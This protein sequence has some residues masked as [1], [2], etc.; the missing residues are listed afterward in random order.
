MLKTRHLG[1]DEDAQMA[2]MVV[3]QVDDALAR[4]LQIPGGPVDDGYPAK[5]LMRRRDIVA[6]GGENDE[7]ILYTPQ[8]DG[9]AVADQCA[10]G[11]QE[12]A[13][14]LPPQTCHGRSSSCSLHQLPRTIENRITTPDRTTSGL[15]GLPPS[16]LGR[17]LFFFG[18]LRIQII[19]RILGD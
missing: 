6:I 7:R 11:H 12:M 13:L 17:L 5:R 1:G 19:R 10:C 2:D 4:G 3:G 9:A 8:I 18:D 15:V 14:L 16:W